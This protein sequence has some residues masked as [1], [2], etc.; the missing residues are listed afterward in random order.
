MDREADEGI[1]M[2]MCLQ[3]LLWMFFTMK[4]DL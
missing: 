1:K 2:Q 3:M 4:N